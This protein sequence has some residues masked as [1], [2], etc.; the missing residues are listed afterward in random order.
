[1][2]EFDR[3][4]SSRVAAVLI[5]LGLSLALG[6]IAF[7][8]W[9]LRVQELPPIDQSHT[10]RDPRTTLR[11]MSNTLWITFTLASAFIVGSF[12]MVRAGRYFLDKS[13]RSP[14]TEYVDAWGRYRVSEEEID[15]ATQDDG[16]PPPDDLDDR[17]SLEPDA[18]D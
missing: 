8:L 18:R 10:S 12:V 4:W 2:A 1:M 3:P 5:A 17:D 11:G 6:G 7:H 14:R 15:A 9:M 16:R 13:P